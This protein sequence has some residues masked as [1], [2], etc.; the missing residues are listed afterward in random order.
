MDYVAGFLFSPERDRVLLVE[1]RRPAWQ[2]GRLNGVGGKV[3]QGEDPLAAMNRE[4]AEEAGLSG[5][6]WREDAVLRGAGFSVRFYSAFSA[7]IDDAA[8][9]TDEP[10]RV[11]PVSALADLPVLGNLRFLVPLALDTSGIVKPVELR[12]AVAQP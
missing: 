3:E 4:F 2:A 5:L 10:V 1:K 7:A 9:L 11:H 8:A 6:D 12:D